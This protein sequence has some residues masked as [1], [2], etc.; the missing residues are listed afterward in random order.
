MLQFYVS[1]KQ[2][3]HSTSMKIRRPCTNYMYLQNKP[4]TQDLQ[5]SEYHALILC[6]CKTSHPLKI[7]EDQKIMHQFYVSAKQ[8]ILKI[9]EDQK[10]MHQFNVS[11]N[12]NIHL[13]S[14]KIRRSCT[15][16]M[17]LQNK[18]STQDQCR[19]EDGGPIIC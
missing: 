1:A 13:R 6:I 18:S 12:Q 3:I 8:V 11:A 19:S 14:V 10:I 16:S 9:C 15:N 17:Y 2:V 5:R 7:Y 4:S